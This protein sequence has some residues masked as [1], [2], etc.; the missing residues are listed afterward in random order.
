MH[1]LENENEDKILI[2]LNEENISYCKK[3]TIWICDGTFHA[4]PHEFKQLYLI[5]MKVNEKYYAMA[6]ILMNAKSYVHYKR[7]F[8]F[9]KI[10]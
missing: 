1:Q 8:E 2:L 3:S 9:L 7:V 5:H 6:Y 10:N 4:C